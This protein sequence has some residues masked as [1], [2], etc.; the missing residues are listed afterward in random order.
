MDVV[1]KGAKG[2]TRANARNDGTVSATIAVTPGD[3]L[4][5]KIGTTT[6]ANG[7][8]T[9][10]TANNI[11]GGASDIRTGIDHAYFG[12]RRWRRRFNWGMVHPQVVRTAQVK[13]QLNR[14]VVL[15]A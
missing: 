7:G 2:G 9:G 6:G 14:L 13:A 1:A 5:I 4:N 8:D 3:V 11:G 12:Y 15:V 10:F